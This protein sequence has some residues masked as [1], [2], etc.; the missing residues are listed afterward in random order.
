MLNK[1]LAPPIVPAKKAKN[2]ISEM[3]NGDANPYALLSQ[4]F[5]KKHYDRQINL[6]DTDDNLK[7]LN[8]PAHQPKTSFM[9]QASV[10]SGHLSNFTYDKD[11]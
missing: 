8:K 11:M 1:Q 7:H 9:S 2:D 6:F 4:N 3:T 5:D 10:D